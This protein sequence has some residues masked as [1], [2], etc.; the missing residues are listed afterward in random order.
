MTPV[1]QFFV[2][3]PDQFLM[4]LDM[5]RGEA[6]FARSSLRSSCPSDANSEKQA[7]RSGARSMSLLLVWPTE[8]RR[9]VGSHEAVIGQCNTCQGEPDLA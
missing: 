7:A 8:P 2:S 6:T 4:S 3:P 5:P 1:D 9:R